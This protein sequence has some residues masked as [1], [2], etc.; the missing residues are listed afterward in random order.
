MKNTEFQY[1]TAFI[2]S[3]FSDMVYERNLVMY[4]VLPKVRKWAFDHGI[5]FDIVDLRWGISDEQSRDLHHTIKICL[6]KVK[7]SDPIF[8]CF[9]GERYGWIPDE[10]DFNQGM[11]SRDI[12]RYKNLSATELE[13]IQATDAA[14]FE[15]LP[16]SSL[17]LFRKSLDF[18]KIP[19]D[20]QKKYTDKKSQDKLELLKMRI[21]KRYPVIQYD[22]EFKTDQNEYAL[23]GFTAD[24]ERLEDILYA[25]L[26]E[27]LKEKYNI[28]NTDTLILENE[29]TLQRFYT[30][31]LSL[32]PPVSSCSA[33]INDCLAKTQDY[34]FGYIGIEPHSAA[35]SQV[36]H[37]SIKQKAKG[38]RF[39]CRFMGIDSR[40]NSVNDVVISLA[41]EWKGDNTYRND[42]IGALLFMKKELEETPNDVFL[43]IAGITSEQLPTYINVF[44]GLKFKKKLL[45]IET[46]DPNILPYYLKYTNND[47]GNLTRYMLAQN[48]KSLTE[49]QLERILQYGD[50]DYSRIKLLITYLCTFA[51]HETLDQTL[52][53]LV[54]LDHTTLT[55]RYLEQLIQVQESHQL[56]GIMRDVLE[57]LCHSPLSLTTEDI[58][59][60]IL[61][62]RDLMDNC[63]KDGT[64]YG[65]KEEVI[66]EVSFSLAFARDY[67]DEYDSRFKINDENV[68]KI[69]M[70]QKVV[71]MPEGMN[72]LPKE[73]SLIITLRSI[74]LSRFL[75]QESIDKYDARNF[76]EI[77]KDYSDPI[78]R[79][80]FL[81]NIIQKKENF[82][83][84]A[85]ALN[86]REL[87]DLFKTLTMQSEGYDVE[88]YFSATMKKV[89]PRSNSIESTQGVIKEKIFSVF[90]KN[91]PDN[92]FG[93][94]YTAMIALKNSDIA[95]FDAFT[96]FIKNKSQRKNRPP[97][98]TLPLSPRLKITKHNTNC[99]TI[100]DPQVQ[101]YVTRYYCCDN[102][103]AIVG[104]IYSGEM[105][106]AYALPLNAGDIIATFYQNRNLHIIFEQ[107]IITVID[108]LNEDVKSYKFG[109]SYECFTQVIHYHNNGQEIAVVNNNRV[110]IFDAMV[111]KKGMK[112]N[113]D[114]KIL[115]A[116]GVPVS[117][118]PFEALI[119]F[120]QN[121]SDKICYFVVDT[122]QMNVHSSFALDDKQLQSITQDPKNG[123]IYLTTNSEYSL[124]L[125]YDNEFR[126]TLDI[127]DSEMNCFDGTC[128]V[129][130]IKDKIYCKDQVVPDSN[131][132]VSAFST[133]KMYG[134][135][136]DKNI[137][138]CFDNG[139]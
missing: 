73:S 33:L 2:S 44:S 79:K 13:I 106:K 97:Y 96:E 118:D 50:R 112:F 111:G 93:Q 69:I 54:G 63:E 16:K 66:N 134:F 20:V 40:I 119:V 77:I 89:M 31:Q 92:E 136:T 121:T 133:R 49:V 37:F 56:V 34:C 67:I 61:L 122:E 95:T 131:N 62:S 76:C 132:V 58:V 108:L 127:D 47:F 11:F 15:S 81:Q 29:E 85:K 86:K 94:Y 6:Q 35:Y 100:F 38:R 19:K 4:N 130:K 139:Y 80:L 59:D 23:G 60:V 125:Q 117:Q 52:N 51:S 101:A 116:Y 42:P 91:H 1:A 57:L 25:H 102:G 88:S 105:E 27:I 72:L 87:V 65:V 83:K 78:I 84:F 113:E 82:Y 124:I 71:G 21:A 5:I 26:I 10:K 9:L 120:A 74:Y 115:A 18:R 70:F 22:S 32:L 99:Y 30:K 48:A 7:D 138:Y 107:G 68:K 46:N 126:L 39:L 8:L 75:T 36:A 24:G 3:T 129:R 137:L 90:R 103:F 45:V 53:V 109:N 123:Y 128:R 43:L 14:F 55:G 17:F 135:I 110:Q 28:N 114:W 104:D 41:C 98:Y 64:F 12:S